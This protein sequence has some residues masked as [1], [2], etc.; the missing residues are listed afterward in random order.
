MPR[1]PRKKFPVV[2]DVW[3]FFFILWHGCASINVVEHNISSWFDLGKGKH[4]WSTLQGSNS[5][6]GTKKK[7]APTSRQ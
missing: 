4:H 7:K 1:C 2:S 3:V 6:T 5:P